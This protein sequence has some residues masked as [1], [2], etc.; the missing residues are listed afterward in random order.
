MAGKVLE[1]EKMINGII[2]QRIREKRVE[3]GLSQQS[4]ADYLELSQQQ[5]QKYEAGRTRIS[6]LNLHRIA[7]YLGTT[8]AYFMGGLAEA[9]KLLNAGSEGQ[10]SEEERLIRAFSKIRSKSLRK[11]IL[12]LV[13][14]MLIDEAR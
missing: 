12:T 11:Q 2:G 10:K 9:D 6:P 13:E 3:R 5:F 4:V 1:N 14:G 7:R 8:E